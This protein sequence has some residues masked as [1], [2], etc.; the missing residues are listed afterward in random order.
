[1]FAVD[2]CTLAL[3]TKVASNTLEVFPP[4]HFL[5]FLLYGGKVFIFGMISKLLLRIKFQSPVRKLEPRKPIF[6][7]FI[8]KDYI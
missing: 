2:G 1:M 8:G 5:I 4:A 6:F 3:T 7:S